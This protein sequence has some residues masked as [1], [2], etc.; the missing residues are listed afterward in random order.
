MLHARIVAVA[1]AATTLAQAPTPAAHDL[2]PL[3]VGSE[4]V[5]D[6][7]VTSLARSKPVRSTVTAEAKCVLADGR[8]VHQL[9]VETADEKSPHFEAWSVGDDGITRF[10]AVDAR[11][12]GAIA[13]DATPLAWLRLPGKAGSQWQWQGKHDIAVAFPERG[14]TH[15][16][17]IVAGEELVA[18]PA[19]SFRAV[20]V[21]VVSSHD[22]Q[23]QLHRDLWFAP[24]VGI[25]RE[26][27][28]DA[29]MSFQRELVA[30]RT[31]KQDREARLRQEIDKDLMNP[32][33]PAWN[34]TP[35]VQWIEDGPEALLLPGALA[36]VRTDVG[37]KLWFVG[38]DS[39]HALQANQATTLAPV[40]REAFGTA[41]PPVDAPIESLARLLA[42]AEAARLGF[43]RIREVPVTLAPPR[44]PSNRSHRRAAVEVQGGALD[45]TTRRVA[46]WVAVSQSSDVQV[47]TDLDPPKALPR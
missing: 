7:T 35:F 15:V 21:R 22:G 39:V 10:L 8:E 13:F 18:V 20:H 5:Y 42:R 26:Q 25:V 4:W 37:A 31:A 17:E 12:R 19:G 32:A 38:A 2:M 44:A 33:T 24:N 3:Q 27:H 14:W 30:F 16:A 1:F 43:A 41:M 11:R 34:N 29:E 36:V 6:A 9:R 45:G 23:A 47:A 28:R 40:M 46:V